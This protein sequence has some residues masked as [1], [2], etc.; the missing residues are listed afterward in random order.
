MSPYIERTIG[1]QI[2]NRLMAEH[3]KI[4]ILYGQRQVGKTTLA[5]HILRQFSDKKVLH[6]NADFNPHATIF[7]SRDLVQLR[8]FV[9]GYDFL[10]ID[11]ASVSPTLVSILK[12]YT[13]IFQN[14][15]F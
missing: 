4:I 8:L 6:I 1:E 9:A 11:E 2:K 12:Y 13:T 15:V 3:H 14:C 5:Q 10:F 7:S